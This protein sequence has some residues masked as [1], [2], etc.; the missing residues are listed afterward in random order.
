MEKQVLADTVPVMSGETAKADR[1]N[2]RAI[3]R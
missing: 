3:V 1:T 2:I